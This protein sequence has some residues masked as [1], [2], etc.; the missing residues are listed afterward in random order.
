MTLSELMESCTSRFTS[1]DKR[2]KN[3]GQQINFADY[4][5]SS[6]LVATI[7]SN[8]WPQKELRISR[9]L[10]WRSK[11]PKAL[12]KCFPSTDDGDTTLEEYLVSSEA[13]S[14]RDKE[15]NYN[16]LEQR[17]LLY[18]NSLNNFSLQ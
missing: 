1:E 7:C 4:N 17:F 2:P 9:P 8:N 12:T 6:F 5:E 3:H 16:L 11:V 10:E 14:Q 15:P 18:G 13:S